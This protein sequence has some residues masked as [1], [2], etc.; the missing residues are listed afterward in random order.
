LT[1]EGERPVLI[2]KRR[3]R[4]EGWLPADMTGKV[5]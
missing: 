1:L 4:F 5:T 3:K 2:A